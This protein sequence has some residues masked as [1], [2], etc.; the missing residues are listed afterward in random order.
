[1]AKDEA[2]ISYPRTFLTRLT[3][4]GIKERRECDKIVKLCIHFLTYYVNGSALRIFPKVLCERLGY[5]YIS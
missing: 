4:F 1:V 3:V 5:A 2:R